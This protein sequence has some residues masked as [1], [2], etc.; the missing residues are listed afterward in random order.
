[1]RPLGKV[2]TT[3]SPNLAYAVGLLAT[4]GSL[5]KDGR[6]INFTSKDYQ[7]V[8]TFRSCLGLSNKIGTK[9]GS[10]AS[11]NT[12][13]QVQFG[14]VLFYRWLEQV[15]LHPHKAKTLGPLEI[16]EKFFF[17][18]LRG[19]FDGDGTIWGFWDTRWKN[20]FIFYIAF[21]SASLS[22]LKWTQRCTENY[23][24]IKGHLAPSTR[25][26]QLRYGKRE[27][28]ILFDA[29]YYKKNLPCLARKRVKALAIFAEDPY[30]TKT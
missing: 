1:M 19:C 18:F 26:T 30:H 4:D 20:S 17:D 6:H 27:A 10:Y 5:S 24:N 29:M 11:K 8:D 12:Y 22:F 23:A 9:S 25:T 28:R 3:W 2:A 21:A 13:Y 14:D 16:P 7:L 15:G